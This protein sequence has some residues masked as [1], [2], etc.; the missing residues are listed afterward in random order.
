MFKRTSKLMLVCVAL[1]AL[2]TVG[3]ANAS[4]S[5][6]YVSNSAPVV[7]NG[8]SC[9]QPGYSKIQSAISA[10]GTTIN[11]CSGTY[12][13]QL[14]ITKAAKLVAING[15]GTATVVMPAAAENSKTACDTMVGE[16]KDEISICTSGT[17]SITGLNVEAIIPTSDCGGQLY[18][19]FVGGG[20]TLKSTNMAIN[21]ASTNVADLKGCQYGVAV[22]V[23]NKTPAEVGHAT[24][25]KDTVTGYQ[26][27]GP[28]VKSSGSTMTITASTITGE[29]PSPTIAQNG[30]QISFGAQGKIS[31]STISGNECELVGTC[32]STNVAEQATGVL[33]YQA[34]SG[35]HLNTST[36]K[37]NDIGA[38]YASG[39]ATVPAT[40]DV[41]LSKDV[42]TSNRYEGVLLEE[43]KASLKTDTIN[44]SGRVG[45]DLYQASY[46]ESASE[47]SATTTK[48]SGQSEASIK[49][50]SDKSPS[51][52]QG[53]F[54]FSK[55]TA[56][57]PVLINEN[58]EKFEV[59]F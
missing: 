57:V 49:V 11:V 18:G 2:L 36:V 21:G 4:A 1:C 8:K 43:G 31:S 59:I 35:S 53:K 46:Q 25:S 33:F 40:P 34:A 23:G 3:V 12:T 48:I 50:E 38:Y 13:E 28:T 54:V 37:E 30:V 6:V 22:E 19:I 58:P 42:F 14:E 51:D 29:G 52:I 55:G 15:A 47:S 20:G 24:L 16:Q 27:N 32:S 7:P 5:A 10:G 44:G 9:A 56:A 41:T 39:S 45:I 26:K 17:V